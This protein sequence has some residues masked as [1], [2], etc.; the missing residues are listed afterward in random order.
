MNPIKTNETESFVRDTVE[1]SDAERRARELVES[2]ERELLAA[3]AAGRPMAGASASIFTRGVEEPLGK[4]WFGSLEKKEELPPEEEV[5]A[6]S[7]EEEIE[8]EIL[9]GDM[10]AS[11]VEPKE[12][13]EDEDLEFALLDAEEALRSK[14]EEEIF[15]EDFEFLM[16][17]DYEDELG[18]DVGFE[19]VR[20]YHENEMNGRNVKKG[21]GR[22]KV[23][24][25]S[26]VEDTTFRREYVRQRMGKIVHLVI[27]VLM[28]VLIVLYER[29]ALMARALGGPFDGLAYP[30]AYMLIGVQ[31][32]LIDA[33]FFVKPLWEG[34]VRLVRFS[35]VDYSFTSV[36]VVCTFAYH[37]VLLLMP[38]SGYPV[39]YLSPAAFF[40]A[41]LALVELLNWHR[42]SAAFDVISS[43]RQKYALLS[44][45]SVGGERDAAKEKLMTDEDGGTEYFARPVGFVRNYF[46]NTEKH[47]EHHKTLGA[48]LLLTLALGVAFGL[49]VRVGTGN[50][51]TAL[52]TVFATMLLTAP[53]AS[54]LLTSLPMFFSAV[55]TQRGK[56]AIIGEKPIAQCAEAATIVLPDHEIFAVM[57]HEQFHLMNGADLYTVTSLS[58]ALLE[59]IGSPLAFAF[60]VDESSRID[61]ESM[62]LID[63][64]DEGIEARF[65]EQG[66]TLLFGTVS[67]MM[68]RGV[69]VHGLAYDMPRSVYNRLHC[70]AINGRAC[71]VFLVRYQ[72][73]RAAISMFAEMERTDV[74]VAIR[75]IDPCVRE[76][77]LAR[78]LRDR[79][80]RV[81]VIKPSLREMEIRTD[82][83]DSTIV[84][85]DS[86]IEAARAYAAC[87]RIRRAGTWGKILQALS[88]A[89]GA[90][91]IVMLSIV[92]LVPGGLF[93]TLW[94]FSW[95]VL[96]TAV[97]FGLLQRRD[98]ESKEE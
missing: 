45:V 1:M 28:F 81:K 21:R 26:Q 6:P 76:E 34:L 22:V 12:A 18:S 89:L 95:C 77:I 2:I 23:E 52:H 62:T 93:I 65:D 87:R 8:G 69:A 74:P 16:K 19:K 85:I 63:V 54:L 27:A 33:A 82:R 64:A 51:L 72:L 60:D 29:S 56:S 75:T 50:A 83:V 5:L 71:A 20:A 10:A 36:L 73:R 15:D 32:L 31:L 91:V 49:V 30:T 47:M 7:E 61:P 25:E 24:F 84:S 79:R 66:G 41:L 98:E 46:T 3:K 9:L 4:G 14:K 90:A 40:L 17:M 48:Q 97:S 11:I 42:E 37:Y 55:L 78:I 86:A 43:R 58:R 96:Y 35:P 44:R 88:M 38:Q 59:K 92:R 94:L 13:E 68:E 67:Y 70:V 57:E 39:L 80:G 53:F